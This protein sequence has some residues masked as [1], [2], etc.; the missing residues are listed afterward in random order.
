MKRKN[1]ETHRNQEKPPQ[2]WEKR[3]TVKKIRTGRDLWRASCEYFQW[4]DSRPIYESKSYQYK[5]STWREPHPH[6]RPYTI[7]GL[8]TFLG[9]YRSRWKEW[10]ERAE[11]S[12]VIQQVEEVIYTQKF[13]GASVG[14][15]NPSIIARDLGLKDGT[16][17][18]GPDGESIRIDNVQKISKLPDE[19]LDSLVKKIM[20]T[21]VLKGDIK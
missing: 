3:T 8:C 19:T 16:E 7:T 13:E 5:E 11:F 6:P 14:L 9:I 1:K 17:I 21:G 10:R 2:W 15:F 12:I 18:S 20:D 4:I